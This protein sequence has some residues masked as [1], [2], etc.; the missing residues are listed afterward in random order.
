MFIHCACKLQMQRVDTV[1]E[2]TGGIRQWL[3]K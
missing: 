2:Q 3:Q 1:Q